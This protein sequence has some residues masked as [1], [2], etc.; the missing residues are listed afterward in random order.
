MRALV[1]LVLAVTLRSAITIPQASDPWV[2]TLRRAG[3]VWFGMS[4]AQAET[5][6]GERFTDGAGEGCRYVRT[7]GM[8]TALRFMAEGR[9][10]VRADIDSS[11]VRTRSGAAVGMTETQV[12]ALYP[13]RIRTEPHKYTGPEGHYLVYEPREA[14]DSS[15]RLIFETDGRLVLNYRVGLRPA[16][17]YVEGCS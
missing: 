15:Y 1:V 3:P 11:G 6:L 5:A 17:D 7:P 16:V 12:R 9:R 4:I 14:S 10:I 2:I 8:P 13:G